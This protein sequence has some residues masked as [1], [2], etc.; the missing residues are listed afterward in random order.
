MKTKA[1]VSLALAFAMLITMAGC[2]YYQ[3]APQ[4]QGSAQPAQP[5]ESNPPSQAEAEPA[6][7]GEEAVELIIFAAASM[8]ATMEEIGKAYMEKIRIL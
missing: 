8:T 2:S 7:T 4:T 1:F 3:I 5:G 6:A